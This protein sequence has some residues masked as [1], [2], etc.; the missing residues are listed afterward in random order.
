MT[1]ILYSSVATGEHTSIDVAVITEEPTG[2]EEKDSA[3]Y[4]YMY[5]HAYT[6]YIAIATFISRLRI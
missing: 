3:T 2:Y 6:K 5:I 1:V 4:I